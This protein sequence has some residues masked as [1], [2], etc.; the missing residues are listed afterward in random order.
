MMSDLKAY[1]AENKRAPISDL[2]NHFD[3]EPTAIRGMLDLY[4]RK[5]RVR[6]I[7]SGMGDC[8][9]CTKCDAFALE[10][11]EWIE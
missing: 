9:G 2:V 4:I 10:I 11:Y 6:L 5:S 8:G 1:L 3:S 7:D